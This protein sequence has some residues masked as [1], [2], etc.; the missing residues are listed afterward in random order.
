MVKI[1]L[2]SNIL[3]AGYSLKNSGSN[4]VTSKKFIYIS[5]FAGREAFINIFNFET[6]AFTR[7]K[8]FS[9]LHTK[10]IPN[11]FNLNDPSLSNYLTSK[12]HHIK[13]F[14]SSRH[15]KTQHRFYRIVRFY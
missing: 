14:T 6:D 13:E 7:F 8:P 11:N 3:I 12:R 15:N 2:T 1:I 9:V 5:C 10:R 4:V